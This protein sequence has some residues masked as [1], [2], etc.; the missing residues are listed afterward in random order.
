MAKKR[1]KKKGKKWI[2]WIVIFL[3]IAIIFTGSLY[4]YQKKQAEKNKPPEFQKVS[5]EK[6]EETLNADPKEAKKYIGKKVEV[7]GIIFM[8]NKEGQYFI[9]AK[10][11][12]DYLCGIQVNMKDGKLI[13]E[14]S[15][16]KVGD[17]ITVKGKITSAKKFLGYKMSVSHVKKL[18]PDRK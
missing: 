6:M 5:I 16:A 11:K 15:D 10:D 3:V 4:F 9:L 1:R 2:S 7:T 14:M 18:S 8:T 17:K 13:N 12:E